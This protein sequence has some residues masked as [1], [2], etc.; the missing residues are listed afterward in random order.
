M[1]LHGRW[2]PTA[3]FVLKIDRK[4]SLDESVE[5]LALEIPVR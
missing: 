2:L 5:P 3:V 4:F 1:R